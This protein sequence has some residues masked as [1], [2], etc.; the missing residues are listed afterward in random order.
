[1]ASI[2]LVFSS[3]DGFAKSSSRGG[4]CNITLTKDVDVTIAFRYLD[5]EVG[6]LVQKPEWTKI[7]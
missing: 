2:Q 7:K 6:S 4:P 1:M 5:K 3:G